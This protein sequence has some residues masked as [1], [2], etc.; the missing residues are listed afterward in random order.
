MTKE[1]SKSHGKRD[2]DLE[3]RT[4]AF[5]ETVIRFARTLPSTPVATPLIGQFIRSGTSIGAN[6]CEAD[7][8]ESKKDFIH[9]IAICRKE[10]RETKFWLRAI[11]AAV[12]ESKDKA[13]VLWFEARELHLIF[14][15]IWRS[16]KT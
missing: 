16:S 1:G 6:Y 2:F 10:A 7:D 15:A 8:A 9:K 13:R 3:E 12:P 5:A 4:A 11:A 14:A